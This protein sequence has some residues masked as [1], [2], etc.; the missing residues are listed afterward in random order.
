M[1]PDLTL[2]VP[3][4][5]R[6]AKL[7]RALQSIPGAV[8]AAHEVLVVD[9]CPDGSGFEVARRHGARYVHKAGIERGLSASRN[10]G[11]TLARG[12]YLAF[13]DD[14]D[15]FLPQ[16]LDRLLS[17][18]TQGHALVFGDYAAFNTESRSDVSLA[19]V[20][21][22]VLLVCNQIPVG[23]YLISRSAVSR[24]FD[25]RLRSHEDWDFL[26]S[27]VAVADAMTHVPGSVVMIDKT[28]N[29]SSSMQARRRKHFW[30]DFLSIYARFPASHL[31]AERAQMLQSLGLQIPPG[32]LQF[33][34]DI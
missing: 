8:S 5:R 18:A 13:L 4:Y 32:M 30:L 23:A 34:D 10:V 3:T 9:D 25:V 6:P 20:S 33:D 2:V 11:L 22:D 29:Q 31:S 19:G 16:G 21:V 12:R 7:E 1:T 17:A 24:P 15:F 28:E 26:L 14:D 27:H